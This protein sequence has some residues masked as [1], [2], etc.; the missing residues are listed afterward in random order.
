[1]EQWTGKILR[2]DLTAREFAFEDIDPEME[3]NFIGGRG[4]GTKIYC[5]EVD[6]DIDQV[7]CTGC[8]GYLSRLRAMGSQ[9]GGPGQPAAG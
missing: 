6:A 2:V 9:P 1:M 8:T 5:D 3:K 7:N 4:V